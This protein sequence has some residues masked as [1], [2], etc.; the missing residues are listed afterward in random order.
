MSTSATTEKQAVT[1]ERALQVDPR[2][3]QARAWGD[4]GRTPAITGA[5]VPDP[6][7]S[8]DPLPGKPLLYYQPRIRDGV[9]E[10]NPLLLLFPQERARE[11]ERLISRI[12]SSE[13]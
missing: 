12:G 10:H 1:D 9:C 13:S 11:D 2:V 5:V 6:P 8:E 3:A 7:S 4:T